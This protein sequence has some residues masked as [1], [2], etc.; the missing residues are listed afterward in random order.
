MHVNRQMPRWRYMH[1]V[2][3][4]ASWAPAQVGRWARQQENGSIETQAAA[5]S[6]LCLDNIVLP[7][8]YLIH[9]TTLP[10]VLCTLRLS[11]APP[12]LPTWAGARN[13]GTSRATPRKP[14]LIGYLMQLENLQ[15]KYPC[16]LNRPAYGRMIGPAMAYFTLQEC[17]EQVHLMFASDCEVSPWILAV[18]LRKRM[19]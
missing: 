1:T 4:D 14:N 2:L 11:P 8:S 3:H 16:R 12:G 13:L 5:P 9:D 18:C 6:K 10:S 7:S 17:K 19:K 15:A